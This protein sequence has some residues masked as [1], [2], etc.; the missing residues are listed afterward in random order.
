MARGVVPQPMSREP[1]HREQ[2]EESASPSPWWQGP[3]SAVL[4]FI[5]HTF[6]FCYLFCKLS[7]SGL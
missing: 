5:S 1:T 4:F 2:S 3:A 6:C 7:M